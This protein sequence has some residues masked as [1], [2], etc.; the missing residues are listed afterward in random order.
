MVEDDNDD[1]DDIVVD[2]VVAVECVSSATLEREVL[3]CGEGA[4]DIGMD[5]VADGGCRLEGTGLGG[6]GVPAASM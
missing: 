2:V 4:G 5:T 3:G 1:E 6:G